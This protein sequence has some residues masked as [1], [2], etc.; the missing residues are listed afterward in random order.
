MRPD[1]IVVSD[2]TLRQHLCFKHGIEKFSIEKLGSHASIE[3]FDITVFPWAARFDIGCDETS[4][5]EPFTNLPSGEFTP[6]IASH[7]LWNTTD[8]HEVR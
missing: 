8:Q 2:P 5:S 1:L 3:A 7:V 6:V 4:I